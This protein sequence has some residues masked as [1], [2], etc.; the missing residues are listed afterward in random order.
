MRAAIAWSHDLLTPE[1][2]VLFRR[3]A[4]FAGGFT[5]EAAEAVVSG[6]DELRIDLFEVVASLADK[7]VLRQEA[8]PGGEPRFFM[9]ETVREFA[10][11]QLGASGEERAIRERHANWC[12]ALA[13]SGSRARS[14][15]GR[16]VVG[17]L[18]R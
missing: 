11:E 6:S 10:L 15:R 13:E 8:G 18:G 17:W 4:V 9:L 14:S 2:Q 12:L 3:L 1:E 16:S 7:S 5:L